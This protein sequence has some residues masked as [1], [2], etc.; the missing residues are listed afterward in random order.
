MV[1]ID[2]AGILRTHISII[3]R[4]RRIATVVNEFVRTLTIV[5]RSCEAHPLSGA[6]STILA[7][8]RDWSHL[9]QVVD[10]CDRAAGIWLTA[11]RIFQAT[12]G[13]RAGRTKEFV[14]AVVGA[15]IPVIADPV[16]IAAPFSVI[17]CVLAQLDVQIAEII[18][19][20]IVV[21]AGGWTPVL[22]LIATSVQRRRHTH[23]IGGLVSIGLH[24]IVGRTGVPIVAVISE[25]AAFRIVF[26]G[27]RIGGWVANIQRTRQLVIAVGIELTTERVRSVVTGSLH[28]S[29]SIARVRGIA[30]FDGPTTVL[31]WNIFARPILQA[32]VGSA[33]GTIIA[34]PICRT[35]IRLQFVGATSTGCTNIRRAQN[36]VIAV[37]IGLA[38]L[39]IQC[40]RAGSL[41]ARTD[42]ASISA[43]TILI[44]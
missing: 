32:I 16:L 42:L 25:K 17:R 36:A 10:A 38:A 29:W 44:R 23:T 13:N 18:R 1:G 5:A 2:V 20:G 40:V 3:T 11:V 19:T 26:E 43:H 28:T 7:T 22:R 12:P 34:V 41:L 9:A 30:V 21:I 15:R 4:A 31:D 39:R 37:L 24:A 6:I 8:I 33:F 27:A 35:A 14:A